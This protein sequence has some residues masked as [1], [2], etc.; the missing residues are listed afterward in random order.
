MSFSRVSHL[1]LCDQP[2]PKTEALGPFARLTSQ[3]AILQIFLAR[4]TMVFNLLF[5]GLTRTLFGGI[6]PYPI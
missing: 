1:G 3:R 5:A 2:D 6:I 4:R